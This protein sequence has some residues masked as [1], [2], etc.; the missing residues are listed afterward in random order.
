V[1]ARRRRPAHEVKAFHFV[2]GRHARIWPLDDGSSP[3]VASSQS[4]T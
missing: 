4:A 3:G 2:L 1:P